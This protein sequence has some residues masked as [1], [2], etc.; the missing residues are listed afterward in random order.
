[1]AKQ[2]GTHVITNK[3]RFLYTH[4]FE[5]YKNNLSQKESYCTTILI[6]KSDKETVD[7]INAAIKVAAAEGLARGYGKCSK[8]PL[9]DGDN[10]R[11]DDENFKNCY[12]LNLNSQFQPDLIDR[13]GNHI[14]NPDEVYSG[15]YGRVSMNFYAYSAGGNRGV[16]A[17]LGNVQKLEDGERLSGRTSAR[18]DFG[19][20]IEAGGNTEANNGVSELPF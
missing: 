4:L 7:A 17:G 14:V 19:E 12:F 9:R 6:P 10:D 18:T 20:F 1:M 5:K 2:N 13:F 8:S 15:M 16:S 11:P 3:V